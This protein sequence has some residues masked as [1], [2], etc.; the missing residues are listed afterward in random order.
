MVLS[1]RHVVRG[2]GGGRAIKV[3]SGRY[4]DTARA[5]YLDKKGREV[6]WKKVGV[7][8]ATIR[9]PLWARNKF[10]IL[11]EVAHHLHSQ[12][13][14]FVDDKWRHDG[15]FASIYLDLLQAFGMRDEY[16]ELSA[17]YL[18]NKVEF[19]VL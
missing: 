19:K 10:I 16:A 1:S 9:L 8:V 18:K 3:V 14:K 6:S 15:E 2:Y 17:A 12:D 11:H 4:R 13:A 7:G 5:S